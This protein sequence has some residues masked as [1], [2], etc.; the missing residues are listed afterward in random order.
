MKDIRAIEN[1]FGV[2]DTY[3]TLPDYQNFETYVMLPEET[4]RQLIMSVMV[5]VAIL[6]LTTFSVQATILVVVS[7]VLVT[8]Y[9]V[10]L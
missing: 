1:A 3:S 9:T 5:V 10:T 8:V 7:V 2:S 4:A 6:F